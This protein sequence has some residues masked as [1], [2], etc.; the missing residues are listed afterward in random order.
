MKRPFSTEEL[1]ERAL[2]VRREIAYKEIRKKGWKI[3]GDASHVYKDY[4]WSKPKKISK[5]SELCSSHQ[6]KKQKWFIWMAIVTDEMIKDLKNMQSMDVVQ[7]LELALIKDAQEKV[8][9]N[10][11][12]NLLDISEVTKPFEYIQDYKKESHD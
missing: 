4:V 1:A 6:T 9:K 2:K 3:L 7:E 10:V 5:E 8:E 11:V 12:R